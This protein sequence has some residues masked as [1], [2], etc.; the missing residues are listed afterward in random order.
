[1]RVTSRF[2]SESDELEL[3]DTGRRRFVGVLGQ[4][5]DVE[6]RGSSLRLAVFFFGDSSDGVADDLAVGGRYLDETVEAAFREAEEEVLVFSVDLEDEAGV[7]GVG[8]RTTL[9][10]TV[11][12]VMFGLWALAYLSP[13]GTAKKSIMRPEGVLCVKSRYEVYCQRWAL[14]CSGDR[15]G[16]SITHSVLG[17]EAKCAHKFVFGFDR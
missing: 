1:V 13:P 4:D 8:G 12:R 5:D 9:V 10:T 16:A 7:E 11:L 14:A 3:D 15:D 17:E 6:D 2:D